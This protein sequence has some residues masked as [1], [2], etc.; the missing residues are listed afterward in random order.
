[1]R[2]LF[3]VVAFG[4]NYKFLTNYKRAATKSKKKKKKITLDEFFKKLLPMI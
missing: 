2:F 1:M 3:I 4:I